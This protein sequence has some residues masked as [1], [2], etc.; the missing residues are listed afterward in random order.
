MSMSYSHADEI[1]LEAQS[2]PLL[3]PDEMT[4]KEVPQDDSAPFVPFEDLPHERDSILTLRAVI[5]GLLCGGLVN[6]SNI[7]LGLK[8]GWTAGANIF[9]VRSGRFTL[10]KT[11]P[12]AIN[13]QSLDLCY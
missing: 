9:G 7:Y 8:S 4:S 2:S 6:A 3:S 12:D 13:S 11:V 5:V 10:L 1:G